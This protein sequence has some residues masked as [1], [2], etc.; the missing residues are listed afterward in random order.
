M[1]NALPCIG[2]AF[3][4]A[5]SC[6]RALYLARFLTLENLGIWRKA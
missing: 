1:L 2:I 4:S 5:W 3:Y 6:H